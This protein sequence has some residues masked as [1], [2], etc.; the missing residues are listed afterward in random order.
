[1]NRSKSIR[2]RGN[3]RKE[4]VV[5]KIMFSWRSR[6]LAAVDSIT[7]IGID[8][9]NRK[10]KKIDFSIKLFLKYKQFRCH[11]VVWHEPIS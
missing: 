8:K 3:K 2:G 10:R 9:K 1:M 6:K 5:K 11:F 7:P 4:P